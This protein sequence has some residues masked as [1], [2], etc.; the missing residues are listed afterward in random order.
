MNVQVCLVKFAEHN[1]NNRTTTSLG[2]PSGFAKLSRDVS[3]AT[4]IGLRSTLF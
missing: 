2:G 4:S 3:L 1:L